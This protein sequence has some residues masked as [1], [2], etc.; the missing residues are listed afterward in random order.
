MVVSWIFWSDCVRKEVRGEQDY[1][2]P[3]MCVC[4]G[5]G[6]VKGRQ[7]GGRKEGK[8]G[9]QGEGKGGEGGKRWEVREGKR[10]VIRGE[11]RGQKGRGRKGGHC[12]GEAT[13]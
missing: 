9:Q 8:S 4:G 10:G 2:H 3:C 1:L 7:K 13:N 11:V 5:G 6:G 12:Q